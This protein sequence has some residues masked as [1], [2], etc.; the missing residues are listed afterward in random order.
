MIIL[1]VTTAVLLLS[2]IT[3][4]FCEY[5]TGGQ[6]YCVI[7]CCLRSTPSVRLTSTISG[8]RCWWREHQPTACHKR[9][10]EVGLT[11]N[12]GPRYLTETIETCGGV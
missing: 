7:C 8:H 2:N 4:L 1:L 5:D 6:N 10:L 9:Q 12:H 3:V 11:S